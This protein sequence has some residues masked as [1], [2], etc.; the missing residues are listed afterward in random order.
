MNKSPLVSIITPSYNQAKY[1]P[2]TIESVLRQDYP[3]VEY[4]IVDGGST[5]GSLQVIQEYADQLDWW[6]SEPDRGQAEAINKGMARARGSIVAWINSDDIYLPGAIGEAVKAFVTGSPDLIF[7]D[8]ITINEGG[9]PLNPLTFKDWGLKELMRFR[10]ICQPAV[11][12]NRSVWRDL[13]GLDDNFHFMLD[14]H[15]WIRVAAGY[16]I[17]HVR[18]T[19]AASRY[20]REAKNVAQAAG[21]SEE[22]FR[23]VAWLKK[24]P[25]LAPVFQQDKRRILG[26]A[27]RLSARYLL[28]GGLAKMSLLNYLKAIWYWPTYAAQHGHR[29][30]FALVSLLTGVEPT[31][32][33]GGARDIGLQAES[34]LDDWPGL[35]LNRPDG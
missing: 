34:D 10:V 26:G 6:V 11:F 12:L 28:D 7:G 4:G 32:F 35:S 31:A 16:N 29:M 1:L 3:H 17:R 15:L 24:E 25:G 13:G 30:L 9:F 33:R 21:F 8:A 27:Y 18:E 5:D 2:D 23:I 20:H 22:I 14:H 19:I